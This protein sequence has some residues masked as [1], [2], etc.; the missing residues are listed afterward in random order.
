MTDEKTTQFK[1]ITSKFVHDIRGSIT[2][3]QLFLSSWE[4]KL[5]AEQQEDFPTLMNEIEK[6][7]TLLNNF[8]SDYK[9]H[10]S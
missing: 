5:S 2:V 7:K 3:L 8:S 6:I 9:T 1:E 4:N 10:L